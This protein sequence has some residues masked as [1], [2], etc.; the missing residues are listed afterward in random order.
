M[1]NG[2][3]SAAHAATGIMQV[4]A[5][6]TWVSW[7]SSIVTCLLGRQRMFFVVAKWI[8]Y[9]CPFSFFILHFILVFSTSFS[10]FRRFFFRRSLARLSM[11][12][13]DSAFLHITIVC[14]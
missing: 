8:S 11:Q 3:E 1:H 4:T 2:D 6:V 9:L 13:L 10:L 14:A 5:G 7:L 12:L